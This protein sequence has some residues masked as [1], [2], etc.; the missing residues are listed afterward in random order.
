M[1]SFF[2]LDHR[3][4]GIEL[5][6]LPFSRI[7]H[8]ASAPSNHL[9]FLVMPQCFPLMHFTK[10]GVNGIR[11]GTDRCWLEIKFSI[12]DSLLNANLRE[13]PLGGRPEARIKTQWGFNA[14]PLARG[15]GRGLP[16][17]DHSA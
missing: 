1:G 8:L 9:R 17:R 14:W 5:A 2:L 15:L 10:L 3:T 13:T 12:L 16:R 7:L 4:Q 6:I 11:R